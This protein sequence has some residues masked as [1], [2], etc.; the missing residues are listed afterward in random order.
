MI[1]LGR[2]PNVGENMNSST[3]DSPGTEQFLK[4]IKEIRS[5]VETALKKTNEV[6]KKKWDIKK[7]LEIK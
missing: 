4:I 5:R 7:K 6:M 1:N 2:H 3:E